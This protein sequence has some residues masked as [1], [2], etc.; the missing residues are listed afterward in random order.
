MNTITYI[1]LVC[2]DKK[3][4]DIIVILRSTKNAKCRIKTHLTSKKEEG[5]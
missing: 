3:I 5:I 4:L 2:P 1:R